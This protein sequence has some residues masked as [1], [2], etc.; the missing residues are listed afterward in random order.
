[1]K[2]TNKKILKLIAL[3]GIITTSV[4]L[5][6]AGIVYSLKEEKSNDSSD[7][8]PSGDGTNLN[9]SY[10][11]Q[12][13]INGYVEG[14]QF[15]KKIV[16][17]Q[18]D[19]G[20]SITTKEGIEYSNYVDLKI[21][22]V[23]KDGGDEIARPSWLDVQKSNNYKI[24]W[25]NIW[26]NE[27]DN[28]YGTYTFY[29]QSELNN[30]LSQ[31]FTL[32]INRYIPYR[33]IT[34]D[35]QQSATIASG[36]EYEKDSAEWNLYESAGCEVL[37]FPR[38]IT[39]VKYWYDGVVPSI[40]REISFEDN[41]ALQEFSGF[42]AKQ[43]ETLDFSSINNN[44]LNFDWLYQDGSENLKTIFFPQK[45]RQISY[46]CFHQCPNFNNIVFYN[47]PTDKLEFSIFSWSGKYP[48]QNIP[49]SGYITILNSPLLTIDGVKKSFSDRGVNSFASWTL[50]E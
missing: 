18:S 22:N 29:V 36:L 45:F 34:R 28:N 27:S 3:C 5:G 12:Y 13:K 19:S 50:K 2:K 15:A 30:Y 32:K 14:S 31:Q 7:I 49:S 6:V 40:I 33:L 24:V 39:A 44:V 43:I 10:N 11:G 4:V 16:Y 23:R 8:T 9:I 21:V 46:Q 47:I 38:D 42:N 17:E 37:Q 25:Q 48:F 26:N 1:M 20:F 35:V 41:S